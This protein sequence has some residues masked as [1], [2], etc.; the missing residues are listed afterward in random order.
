MD[1]K[2]LEYGYQNKKYMCGLVDIR[3]L[4]YAMCIQEYLITVDTRI[5]RFID[6]I[7]LTMC[8]DD[9]SIMSSEPRLERGVCLIHNRTPEFLI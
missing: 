8:K 7:E 6:T 9:K 3:I 1:I 2:V 4:G 5:L